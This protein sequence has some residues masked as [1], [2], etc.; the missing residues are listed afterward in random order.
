MEYF[1]ARNIFFPYVGRA[2]EIVLFLLATMT[3]VEILNNNCC[4]DF[5]RQLLLTRSAKKMLWIL[6]AVTFIISANL[7][8]L[9]TTVLPTE[10]WSGRSHFD[11]VML[12]VKQEKLSSDDIKELEKLVNEKD[13]V[14]SLSLKS[15]ASL[16]ALIRDDDARIVI[17]PSFLYLLT[18]LTNV[19]KLLLYEL[20]PFA[21]ISYLP[22]ILSPSALVSRTDSADAAA[23]IVCGYFTIRELKELTAK[24]KAS[25]YPTKKITYN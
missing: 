20:I 23:A 24:D 11:Y 5:I 2:A 21:P 13:A 16:S 9:T 22:P 25:N 10:S 3:I 6:A 8:N 17:Y 14:T 12:K 7:D 4:F 15:A 1:I 18:S 19:S